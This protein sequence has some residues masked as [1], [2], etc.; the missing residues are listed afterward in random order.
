MITTFSGE[1]SESEKKRKRG[2]ELSSLLFGGSSREKRLN[3]LGVRGEFSESIFDSDFYKAGGM[4]YE[5]DGN[6]V[7]AIPSGEIPI[8]PQTGKPYTQ[9]AMETFDELREM[10]PDNDL[11]PRRLTA[12][13]KAK[14]EAEQKKLQTATTAVFGGSP[15]A[16]DLNTY[17]GS[18][19]KQGRDRMEIIDYLIAS[20]GGEDAEMDKKFQEILSNIKMQNEG[21]ESEMKSAYSKAGLTPPN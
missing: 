4:G 21:I 10:F 11:I 20:Q 15:N 19:R 1:E 9:E 6:L 2:K 7:T 12:E 16:E 18:V 17:Y 13:E 5:E 14:N 3:P 8:N